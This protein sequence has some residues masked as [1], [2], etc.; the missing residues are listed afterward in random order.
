MNFFT[1]V[2]WVQFIFSEQ[3]IMNV[4]SLYQSDGA[5][6]FSEVEGGLNRVGI[7]QFRKYVKDLNLDLRH[8]FLRPVSGLTALPKIPLINELFTGSI[9]AV[10]RK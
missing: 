7:R 9:V 1:R 6:A 10:L 4:R 5:K 8:L 3:T 2:P